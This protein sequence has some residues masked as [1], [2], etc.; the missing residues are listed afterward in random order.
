MLG[1]L[2]ANQGASGL[3]ATLSDT[4]HHAGCML[5][6]EP[7]HGQI[8]QKE[9][10]LSPDGQ[11]VVRAH[12]HQV[13]THRI[14]LAQKLGDLELGTH[15]VGAR[16][17]HRIVHPLACRNRKQPTEAADIANHFRSI[18]GAHRSLNGI[19]RSSTLLNVHPGIG[20]GNLAHQQASLGR[21]AVLVMDSGRVTG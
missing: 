8:V 3:T 13:N 1:H 11:D 19:H 15:P 7:A 17:E 9:E 2:S 5:A 4:L 18:R 12:G 20:I 6:G 14:M 10:R 16:H 21:N